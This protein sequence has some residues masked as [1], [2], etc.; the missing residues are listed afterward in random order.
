MSDS[1]PKGE[2]GE[3]SRFRAVVVAAL[4]AEQ[5]RRGSKPR[6]ELDGKR[7]KDTSIAMEEVRR[8]LITFTQ[9][10]IPHVQDPATSN[11]QVVVERFVPAIR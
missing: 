2:P 3:I 6:I 10:A 4:R 7:H 1:Q 11:L 9:F 8:G 5:L